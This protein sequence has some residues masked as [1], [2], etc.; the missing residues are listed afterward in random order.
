MQDK[1]EDE[2]KS[3]KEAFQKNKEGQFKALEQ[4]AINE[5][6]FDKAVKDITLFEII[7]KQISGIF[8]AS[9]Y[10]DEATALNGANI[11][12]TNALVENF[13]SR[14]LEE[15]V[16]EKKITDIPDLAQIVTWVEEV[17]FNI[18]KQIWCENFF[19]SVIK[20]AIESISEAVLETAA[21]ENTEGEDDV[22]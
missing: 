2:L 11:D 19:G 8:G 7:T 17:H 13:F 21:E 4:F 12:G 16:N 22:D 20:P 5:E 15:C 10:S 14:Y 18:S 6:D 3:F 9:L 1:I